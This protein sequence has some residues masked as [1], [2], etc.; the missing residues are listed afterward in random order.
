MLAGKPDL[1]TSR[2]AKIWKA[3]NFLMISSQSSFT[4]AQSESLVC[5]LHSS[6][7]IFAL[8]PFTPPP[9]LPHACLPVQPFLTTPFSWELPLHPTSV[10]RFFTD[11]FLPWLKLDL[12]KDT[13]FPCGPPTIL[14]WKLPVPL[15]TAT[16][17]SLLGK[18]NFLMGVLA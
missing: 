16:P 3:V 12:S 4:S 5:A 17:A 11:S 15:P 2:G 9:L 18:L 14:K 8:S 7:P 1:Y 10:G 6:Q 13:P